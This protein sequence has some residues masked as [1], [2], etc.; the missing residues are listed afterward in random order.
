MRANNNKWWK[1]FD[2][3]SQLS[4]G[5]FFMGE[6][7]VTP[8]CVSS[9]AIRTPCGEIPTSSPQKWGGGTGSL[10]N[11][12]FFWFTRVN[13]PN[14]M[15]IASAV[16]AGLTSVTNTHRRTHRHTLS[17]DMPRLSRHLA[18]QCW[19]C[20]LMTMTMTVQVAMVVDRVL[21]LIF[22]TTTLAITAAILSSR[23]HAITGHHRRHLASRAAVT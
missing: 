18:L 3:M 14:G 11:A 22:T 9:R 7:I 10:S 15:S 5:E 19:R 2:E 21:L 12:S 17:Q 1:S 23:Y 4:G 6:F 8:D 13:T 20:G 16:F